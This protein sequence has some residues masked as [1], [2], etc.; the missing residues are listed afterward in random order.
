MTAK[1]IA[2]ASFL[3][4][5]TAGLVAILVADEVRKAAH[6]DRWLQH[7]ISRPRPPVVEPVGGPPPAPT[8]VPVDAVILFDGTNL[9]AWRTSGG[10]PARWTVSD[11]YMEVARGRVRFT[12]GP[13]SATF[14]S[15]S[16]G[17]PLNRRLARGKTGGIAVSS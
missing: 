12:P 6:H 2:I 16:S 15:T 17:P 1:S 8:P 3:L 5:A 10:R 13:S 11:G 4:T 7:D 9:D 14:N